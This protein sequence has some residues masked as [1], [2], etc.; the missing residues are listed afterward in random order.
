MMQSYELMVVYKP[1]LFEDIKKNTISK[2]LDLVKEM[3]GSLT[4][5]DNLGKR[6]IAYTIKGFNEGHYIQYALEIDPGKVDEFKKELQLM[7]D[8]L[9]FLLI[10]Q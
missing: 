10:K 4:E 8:V 9:R 7:Q 6:L 1:I 5:V 2:I 3:G